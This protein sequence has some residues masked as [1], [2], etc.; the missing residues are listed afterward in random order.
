MI[1]LQTTWFFLVGVLLIGYCILDGF[2]LGVGIWYLFAKKDA[3]RRT[4][5][6][7]IGPFWDGNEVW[8]LTGGGA[9]FA[10]FPHVYATVFS[11]FYLALI[12]VL[13]ALILRAVSLEYRSAHT[14]KD[15]RS[16]WDIAFAFGSIVPAL[17]L[18][19]AFGNI[20]RGLPLDADMNFTGSFFTLLNPLSLLVGLVGL[21]FFATHGALYIAIK[22]EGELA[23][24]AVVWAKRA[25]GVYLALTALGMAL[26]AITTPHLVENARSAP[27]LWL[28]PAASLAAVAL[29]RTLAARGEIRKAFASSA[30]SIALLIL[31]SALS[32]YPNIV[33]ALEGPELSLTIANASSSL[34][35]L[36]TMLILALIGVPIVLGYTYWVYRAFGGKVRE[37]EGY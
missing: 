32:L 29:I 11:G 12:L 25:A 9:L 20:L 33:P 35:T 1:A 36:K 6:R 19:V 14:G 10:A 30:A 23:E 2:D 7:T 15:W 18:G 4:L 13:L 37:G 28:L 24:S 26:F 27:A 5:M 21:A 34:L 8:L 3:Q 16:V 22:T 17:L 31:M